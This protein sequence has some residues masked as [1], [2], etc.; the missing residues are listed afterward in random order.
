MFVAQVP[1]H[2]LR[3]CSIF[4]TEKSFF[5][6]NKERGHLLCPEHEMKEKIQDPLMRMIPKT[7][8]FLSLMLHS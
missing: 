6:L 7:P 4:K 3:K 2:Y 1:R 5:S 8:R